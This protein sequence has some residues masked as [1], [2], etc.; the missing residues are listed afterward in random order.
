MLRSKIAF[1]HHMENHEV[2][3]VFVIIEI[4]RLSH[5][6]Y[7]NVVVYIM[8]CLIYTCSYFLVHCPIS[9]TYIIFIFRKTDN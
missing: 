2:G 3:W 6:R 8:L 9:Q 4:N 5:L 1:K 7:F